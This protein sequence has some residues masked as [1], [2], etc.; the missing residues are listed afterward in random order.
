MR[1]L[2]LDYHGTPHRWIS[3]DD[4]IIYHA[5]KL[6][7]WQLEDEREQIV[8]RGGVNKFTGIQSKICSAPIIAVKRSESAAIRRMHTVPA[9]TNRELFR[10]DHF[11]CAYCGKMFKDQKLTRDHIIPRSRGGEDKWMN[12]VTACDKCNRKKDDY[13]LEE[14]DMQLLYLPYAP[15]RAE[16]LIL[17]NRNILACQMDFL[18]SYL[19]EHSRVL[20]HIEPE[21]VL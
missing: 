20:R 11:M 4:A 12:V 17:E 16:A 6:V 10:R 18:K 5:K 8:Y 14:C 1:V 13:L 7:A 19:P 9:L 2:A 21:L 15:N 3:K